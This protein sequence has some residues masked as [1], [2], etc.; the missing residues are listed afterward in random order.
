MEKKSFLIVDDTESI[1]RLLARILE[2]SGHAVT[3]V[4]SAEEGL[5]ALSKGKFDLIFLD[6]G[7]PKMMGLTALTEFRKLCQTPIV[8]ITGLDSDDLREDAMILGARTVLLKPIEIKDLAKTV[9][10]ILG[11]DVLPLPPED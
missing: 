7:L 2:K 4:G 10:S 5:E 1:R 6:D 3:G 9:R 11:D 8:I